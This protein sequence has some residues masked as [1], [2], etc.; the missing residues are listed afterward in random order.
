MSADHNHDIE[1]QHQAHR[2]TQQA[3]APEAL[4]E[5]SA[6]VETLAVA[7]DAVLADP[8]LSGR[9]NAP[10]RQAAVQQMQQTHGNRQVQ[11]LLEHAAAL[12]GRNSLTF[13]NRQAQ[14]LLAHAAAVPGRR[15][16]PSVQRQTSPDEEEAAQGTARDT[17][18]VP[19]LPNITGQGEPH[20]V[21]A[22]GPSNLKIK[23]KTAA[24]F[25]GG[26]FRTENVETTPGTGCKNC[27][28]GNCVHVTGIRIS[29]Y[30][31]TTKVT[32]PQVPRRP[33]MTECEREAVRNA[34][35]TT[36]AEHEQDHVKAFE[37]YN[38]STSTPFDATICRSRFA[39]FIRAQHR[40]EERERRANANAGSGV[41]DPFNFEID[42]SACNN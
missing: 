11:R 35:D 23:G 37:Q 14:R 21:V 19:P 12:P 4:A 41:L 28:R 29:D 10:L 36:L 13:G 20:T 9:G 2:A 15:S 7:P 18:Q 6:E 1:D 38:G 16:M 42:F 40:A 30:T 31:V 22:F 25:D 3:D 26:R 5:G 27:P 8:C 33:K 24:K 39:N 17:A 32:L 34:I